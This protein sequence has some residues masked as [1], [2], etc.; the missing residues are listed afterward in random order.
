MTIRNL[1][2]IDKNQ[3]KKIEHSDNK[4]S[5]VSTAKA[6]QAKD[7]LNTDSLAL[8]NVS[9]DEFDFAKVELSKLNRVTMEQ[10]SDY[11]EMIQEYEEVS[12]QQIQILNEKLENNFLVKNMNDPEVWEMIA[13]QIQLG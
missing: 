5:N 13:K 1:S 6:E 10:L 2:H 7:T 3:V 12:E 9:K 11:R 4:V 8:S